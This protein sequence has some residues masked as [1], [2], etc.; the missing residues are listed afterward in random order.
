M[1]KSKVI[2]NVTSSLLISW[3]IFEFLMDKKYRR[4][5]KRKVLNMINEASGD[6]YKEFYS[7]NISLINNQL[8]SIKDD[9]KNHTINSL[10]KT[11]ILRSSSNLESY[12]NSIN[13]YDEMRN[14][15][16]KELI[17]RQSKGI[18]SYLIS[19]DNM[20]W[21]PYIFRLLFSFVNYNLI[22]SWKS[23]YSLEIKNIG[24]YQAFLIKPK[25]EHFEKNMLIFIGMGGILGPFDS[26]IDLLI[27]KK[28]QIVIPLYGPSMACLNYNI[29]GHEAEFHDQLHNFLK[30]SLIKNLDIVCWSLGGM[31]YKGFDNYLKILNDSNKVLINRV[32]LFEP[33]L[34]IRSASDTYFLQ[35][36]T[37]QDTLDLMGTVTESK[38]KLY[39]YIFTYFL[40]SIIGF[41]T[42]SSFG[43]LSNIELKKNESY[44]IPSYPRYLFLSSD[45]FII[46]Y[47]L[48]KELIDSNFDKSKIYKR[49]G[50]HGGWLFSKKLIP[51]LYQLI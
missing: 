37:Y 10:K 26:I 33:L 49:I 12:I 21:Y 39:N 30:N 45:D 6:K 27:K 41:S 29:D 36:R 8:S 19:I 23:K 47:K 46:N 44:S 15:Q 31:L 22:K 32:F 7:K 20:L 11:F 18:S 4:K 14:K 34:G 1:I 3:V 9:E 50:Y 43:Y 13:L 51:I 40:H 28:Y 48:D 42:C 25:D 24:S 5:L 38:Y 35:V 2:I 16:N 17:F